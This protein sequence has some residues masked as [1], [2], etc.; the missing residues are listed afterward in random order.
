MKRFDLHH[1]SVFATMNRMIGGAMRRAMHIAILAA[2]P[3]TM[4]SAEEPSANR[5]IRPTDARSLPRDVLSD[6]PWR[7]GFTEPIRTLKLAVADAGRVASVDV[8]RGQRVTHGQ[9]LMQLDRRVLEASLAI[10]QSEANDDSSVDALRVRMLQKSSRLESLREI[11]DQGAGSA[12][13]FRQAE[14]ES[15]VARFEWLAATERQRRAEMQVTK[16]RGQWQRQGVTAPMDGVITE[17]RCEVGEYVS[18]AEPHVLTLV[19]LEQLRAT[20]FVP[21]EFAADLQQGQRIAL[22]IG[23][24]APDIRRAT[25]EHVSPV[26]LADSGRVRVDLVIDNADGHLR[27]GVIAYWPASPDIPDR[28]AS[29][30]RPAMATS[31]QGVTR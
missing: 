8:R 22:E 14:S 31:V 17:V 26:T 3:W 2:V 5:P 21:T 13:E 24:D 23:S 7:R 1:E 25:I 19:R 4:A 9:S 6:E 29:P 16:L 20:Y 12:E 15:E 28:P 11:Y 10:A 18:T 30:D 27:S